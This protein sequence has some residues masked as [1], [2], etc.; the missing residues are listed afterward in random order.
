M[1][2]YNNINLIL[3]NVICI[4]LK[5]EYIVVPLANLDDPKFY[6]NLSILGIQFLN[7]STDPV[8]HAYNVTWFED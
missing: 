2:L 3:I 8:E 4:W 6:I 5:S 1:T 7:P